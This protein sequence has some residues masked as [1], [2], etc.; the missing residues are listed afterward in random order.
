LDCSN[1]II[2]ER[3]LKRKGSI[4]EIKRIQWLC[5]DEKDER[6]IYKFIDFNIFEDKK[7]QKFQQNIKKV[8]ANKD[9][10]KEYACNKSRT[11]LTKK[12]YFFK[13]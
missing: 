7:K 10:L 13:K 11:I 3:K 8:K 9:W 4:T 2:Y 1:F 12:I 5:C 6:Y